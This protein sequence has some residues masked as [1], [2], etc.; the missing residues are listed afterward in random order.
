MKE[1]AEIKLKHDFSNSIT[2]IKIISKATTNFILKIDPAIFEANGITLRQI[3]I[4]KQSMQMI[5]ESALLAE[6]SFLEL[7]EIK[8]GGVT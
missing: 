2:N 7:M 3:E 5:E 1:K 8:E 6:N 4:F